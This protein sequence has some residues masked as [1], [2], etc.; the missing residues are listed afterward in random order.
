VS[1][2][3][4]YP[5]L[6]ELAGVACP[7]AQ[8]VDGMSLAPL[9]NGES[10]PAIEDRDLF[11]HYPHYG[12]QGGEPSSIIRRGDWKLIHYW[13]DGRDELY[14]L[15]SDP[16]EQTDVRARNL[17]LARTMRE[18]LDGWLAETG[19]RLP[20]HDP[21]YDDAAFQAWIKRQQTT[22]LEQLEKQHADYLDADWQPNKD[23]WGSA[24][25]ED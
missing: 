18:R 19:A 25:T 3:D 9:L 10:V 12:N 11:W 7:A 24:V 22:V 2:I 15:Q 16:G 5:T 17:E 13:E 1:G 20:A 21:Q 23:W 8:V 6:L 14:N 4:F